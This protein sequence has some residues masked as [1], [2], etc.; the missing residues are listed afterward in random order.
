MLDVR[1]NGLSAGSTG[2]GGEDRSPHGAG[3]EKSM[4]FSTTS[5][6]SSTTARGFGNE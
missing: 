2:E 6:V 5:T 3:K 4:W 1:A